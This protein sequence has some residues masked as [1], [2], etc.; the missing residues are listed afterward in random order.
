MFPDGKRTL[1]ELPKFAETKAKVQDFV[2]EE[3]V[4]AVT[5][6]TEKTDNLKAD[7]IALEEKKKG[8]TSAIAKQIDLEIADK[9]KEINFYDN[10]IKKVLES[11]DPTGITEEVDDITGYKGFIW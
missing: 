4:A 9:N 7:I 1:E 6:L 8:V 2:P 3:K 5:G 11:K 10:Q